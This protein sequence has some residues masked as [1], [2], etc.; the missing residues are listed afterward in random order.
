MRLLIYLFILSLVWSCAH[1]LTPEER[2]ALLSAEFSTIEEIQG[3]LTG[4]PDSA[5]VMAMALKVVPGIAWIKWG[6]GG[7][8]SITLNGFAKLSQ[9]AANGQERIITDTAEKEW[10]IDWLPDSLNLPLGVSDSLVSHLTLILANGDSITVHRA[11]INTVLDSLAAHRIDINAGGGGGGSGE[12]VALS[13]YDAL[14]SY[15]GA[16][17][18]VI[19][20]DSRYGGLFY[21]DATAGENGGTEIGGNWRRVFD[22]NTYQPEWWEIGGHDQSGTDGAIKNECD[23]LIACSSVADTGSTI[24]LRKNK[25][26]LIDRAITIKPNQYWRGN[27]AILK[28]FDTPITA[29]TN[30]ESIGS[31]V[32]EV[33]DTTGFRVG[34]R[35]L[36]LDESDPNGGR[37]FDENCGIGNNYTITAV[38]ASSITVSNNL[39]VGMSSGDSVIVVPVMFNQLS[40]EDYNN[41]IFEHIDFDGNRAGNPYTVDWRFNWT[42]SLQTGKNL[43]IRNCNFFNTPAENITFGSGVVEN[44]DFRNL[45]GSGIHISSDGSFVG[46]KVF[47]SKF[48]NVNE[49]GNG[50]MNHS[51]GAITFS[52]NSQ[53]VRVI[54][55]SFY[56]GGE[57][58]LG[59]S[60]Q[61]DYN[62]FVSNCFAQN[63]S[64]VFTQTTSTTAARYSYFHF[65]N[66][67]FDNC[68][69]IQM[70]GNKVES[71]NSINRVKFLNNTFV[72]S[73]LYARDISQSQFI[74]NEFLYDTTDFTPWTSAITSQ[75]AYIQF[76]DFDQIDFSSNKIIGPRT[77]NSYVSNGVLFQ[78]GL[79]RKDSGGSNTKY[80]YPQ[81]ITIHDNTVANFH[82]GITTV[83]DLPYAQTRQYQCVGWSIKGNK[84]FQTRDINLATRFAGIVVEPGVVAEGNQIFVPETS[85]TTT[86]SIGMLVY[87]SSDSTLQ[88]GIAMNNLIYS[89]LTRSLH[90]GNTSNT[91]T[92]NI[93]S[94][95]N[96]TFVSTTG[97]KTNVYED[98]NVIMNS[99]TIPSYVS[100]A[101]PVVGDWEEYKEVY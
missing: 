95:N 86:N 37:A 65:E 79:R 33:D 46:T 38:G 62:V 52:A 60:G 15:A 20:S 84:V 40:G 18:A 35:V 29:L 51:E 87:G 68:G 83:P 96:I 100:P 43:T 45:N 91:T 41:I 97:L 26:Y 2:A 31:S 76:L 88:G 67:V 94:M 59:I 21:E 24:S 36:I 12:L 55:C 56:T 61:D 101:T 13:T 71:G 82:Q 90:Y 69:D 47:N 58:V 53:D 14:R 7:G 34:H 23:A 27:G 19:I 39:D 10:M 5:E 74:G 4:D 44:C 66:N 30:A 57:A 50:L 3:A 11:D 93:V 17:T 1:K 8:D 72:N 70:Q 9:N 48:T 42:M 6:T 49:V 32:W 64:S 99:S 92:L 22:G 25:T 78:V 28:R 73:R 75:N 54:G 16:A 89:T 77:Y 81:G 80:Y 98:G 63:F 85:G